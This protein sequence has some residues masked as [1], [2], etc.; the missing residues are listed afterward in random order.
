MNDFDR[1]T[2]EHIVPPASVRADWN[3]VLH[4][5]G[6]RRHRRRRRFLALAVSG[7]VLVAASASAFG[8]VREFLLDRGFIGVPPIGAAPST[9]AKGELI[10]SYGGGPPEYT[11]VWVYADGRL[12]TLRY[13]THEHGAS[14][15]TTGF[16]E[17]RLTAEGVERIRS[18][19]AAGTGSA[20]EKA[21]RGSARITIGYIDARRDD[22]LVRMAWLSDP[23]L[24]SRLRNPASWLP[25]TAWKRREVIA[26]VPS[27]YAVCWGGWARRVT[28]K[29]AFALLPG[30]VQTLLGKQPSVPNLLGGSVACAKVSTQEARALKTMLDAALGLPPDRKLG[31]RLNYQIRVR[32]AER[33]RAHVEFEPMLPNGEFTCSSCG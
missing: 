18:A 8:K 4:R 32:G 19:T 13:G 14:R 12:I 9:P 30:G 10:V 7:I 3:D 17:Q 5:F 11:R 31:F 26:Y 2:V 20:E 16:L 6:T 33:P 22:R 21:P 23:R 27:E 29:E 1:A 24:P 15:G 28:A 25:P